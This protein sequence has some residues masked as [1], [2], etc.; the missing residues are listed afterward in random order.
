MMDGEERWI[1]PPRQLRIFLIFSYGWLA[2]SLLLLLPYSKPVPKYKTSYVSWGDL[3][4]NA[5]RTSVSTKEESI[6]N[7]Q[8]WWMVI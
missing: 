1:I 5:P 6:N 7:N 8:H 3:E 4:E 2:W